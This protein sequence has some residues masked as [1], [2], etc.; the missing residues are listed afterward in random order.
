MMSDS[1]ATVLRQNPFFVL[2]VST[3]STAMEVERA[4]Q[5]LL[6]LLEV[7]GAKARY[8]ETPFGPTERTPE[9]VRQSA[10]VLRVPPQ[11]KFHEML[12]EV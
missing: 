6:A 1:A 2:E 4:A 12:A 3:Q 10:A 11:R 8:V 7:G 5:R 9:L